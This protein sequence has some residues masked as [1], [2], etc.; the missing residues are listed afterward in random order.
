MKILVVSYCPTHPTTAGNSRGILG[1]C[2]ILRKLGHDVWFLWV[3]LL[4]LHGIGENIEINLEMASYWGEKLLIYRQSFFEKIY[5]KLISAVRKITDGGYMHVDDEYPRGLDSF[6]A[7]IQTQ[8]RFDACIVNY[9]T[10]SKLLTN[11]NIQKK[12]LFTHDIFSYKDFLTGEKYV[13]RKCRANT[14]AIA[15]QRAPYVF[16][17]QEEEQVFF[18]K[19]SPQSKVYT[20]YALYDVTRQ[21]IVGNHN[22]LFLS[23]PNQYNMHGLKWFL[24]KI[25]PLVVKS[26]ADAK[27]IVGG[28]ICNELMGIKQSPNIEIYGQVKDVPRFFSLGDVAINP[29]YEGTGLK[30]KTFESMSFGKIVLAHPHSAIGIYKRESAPLFV[31]TEPQEW[32]DYLKEIWGNKDNM[33]NKMESTIEYMLDMKEYVINQYKFFLND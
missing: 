31:S 20:I 9:Y 16:A 3:K 14:E 25:M 21:K 29:T 6:T 10:Y 32:V 1:Y 11:L 19:L 15:C 18:Q 26:F 30:V 23:G 12:A 5:V 7:K 22:I 27:L 4:P 13:Y 8:Y 24:D 28:S 33:S 17:V 2:D